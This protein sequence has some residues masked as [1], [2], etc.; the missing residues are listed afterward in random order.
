MMSNIVQ[1]CKYKKQ[2]LTQ[3]SIN[4]EVKYPE[5][6]QERNQSMNTEVIRIITQKKNKSILTVRIKLFETRRSSEIIYCYRY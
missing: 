6:H 5:C 2:L 4:Q 1:E 3:N